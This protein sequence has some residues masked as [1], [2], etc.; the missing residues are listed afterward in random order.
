MWMSIPTVNP[1]QISYNE[2]VDAG[3]FLENL[4]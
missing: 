2:F 1:Q 4:N 3:K